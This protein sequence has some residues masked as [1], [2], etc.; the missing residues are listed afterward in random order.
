MTQFAALLVGILIGSAPTADLLGRWWGVDLRGSGTANP[1]ANNAFKLG[2][3]GLGIAVLMVEMAKG[4]VAVSGGTLLGGD[5]G[6]ALAAIGSIAGNV[7]NPWFRFRGGKGLGITGGTLAGAWPPLVP[8]LVIVIAV[9]VAA[10]RRSGPASL[11]TF[12]VYVAAAVV[13]LFVDLPT[14]WGLTSA[15]WLAVMAVGS[16]A[17][18]LPKHGADARPVKSAVRPGS[19]G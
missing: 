11:V 6:G 10:M 15:G 12:A 5:P 14:G 8:V 4:V 3:K 9:S 7:Y 13:G 17:V 1:G 18:M 2:G 16:V 19:P